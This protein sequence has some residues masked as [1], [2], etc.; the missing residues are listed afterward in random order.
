MT[1]LD[2]IIVLEAVKNRII[3]NDHS[4]RSLYSLITREVKKTFCLDITKESSIDKVI[5]LFNHENAVKY[6][7]ADNPE[8][9]PFWW[10]L[11]DYVFGVD[12]RIKFLDWMINELKAEALTKECKI[13]LLE[14]VKDCELNKHFTSGLCPLIRWEIYSLTDKPIKYSEIVDYI[15]LFTFEN[16]TEHANAKR[17]K[18]FWWSCHP[19]NFKNRIK[20]LD[21]MIGELKKN[22]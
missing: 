10:S 16:A 9:S 8:W 2:Q 15:P 18:G 20:F 22:D 1:N 6:G 14:R 12:N 21:W 11:N 13:M 3:L 17:Y 4:D 19:Y 5:P 7:N